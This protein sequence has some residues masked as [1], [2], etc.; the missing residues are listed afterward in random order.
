MTLKKRYLRNIKNN[1]SFYICVCILTTLVV[2]LYLDFAAAAVKIGGD[3]DVFY[4]RFKVENAQFTVEDEISEEDIEKLEKKYDILL[5]KQRYIDYKV[6]KDNTVIGDKKSDKNVVN[7]K[8]DGYEYELRIMS[9]PKKINLFVMA[10]GD[11]ITSKPGTEVDKGK[12]IINTGLAKGNNIAKGDMITLADN[13]FEYSGE[14]ER[15]D[16]L[17]PIKDTSDTFALK[18]EFGIGMISDEEFEELVEDA[19][20]SDKESEGDSDIKEYY[21]IRYNKD[22]ESEVRKAINKEY[23]MLSYLKAE[24]NTRTNIPKT[25]IEETSNMMNIVILILVIFIS[26]IISVVIGRKIK[27][28]R[29]QIGVLIALGYR[30]N[31]LSMHYAMY[32]IILGLLGTGM[33]VILS[34]LL[35]DKLLSNLFYKI[36]PIPT[37]YSISISNML[38]AILVPTGLYTFS[39]YRSARKVMKTDVI[40]MI[41]GRSHGGVASKLRMKKSRLS[42]KTKFKLRQ[43]FGKPGRSI[44]VVIGLAF[45]GMLYAFCLSCIDSMDAYVKHTVDQIGTFNYEY[46]L[47]TPE[48]GEPE[49][50]NAILGVSY[51]VKGREDILMLL[52]IDSPDMINFKDTDGNELDFEED[53]YYITSMA[54]LAFNTEVGDEITIV[55]PITLDEYTV[56]ITDIVKNDSQAAIYCSRRNA[57]ELLDIDIEEYNKLSRLDEMSEDDIMD[58]VYD[59]LD[60]D[61]DKIEEAAAKMETDPTSV[62]SETLDMMER[63]KDLTEDDIKDTIEG[64]TAEELGVSELKLPYNVIMSEEQVD[65]DSDK[66]VKT[67]SK[68][69]L[70]DQINEVKTS[71][72]DLVGV[73]NIFAIIICVVVVYMMVNVLITESTPSVSMLKVLGYRNR[74]INSMVLNVYHFLVPIAIVLSFLLGFFG[75][76]GVFNANVSVYK[77]YLATCIYPISIVKMTILV[78]VSYILSLL[79]LRGKAGKVD[80]VESLKD[81]R[82]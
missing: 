38:I 28:D 75:T 2:V 43:I 63:A 17:F 33:G 24:T 60:I 80:L 48:L 7:A 4:D 35:S 18:S 27:N 53:H 73:I 65:I 3:L 11:V 9:V 68:Q 40:T 15:T 14:F 71:M 1:L 50:G 62:D 76:K 46:F 42:V 55:D 5:E 10:D 54:S 21:V 19:L 36:E 64:L 26:I 78:L 30:K 67:I 72:E 13:K 74:E 61:M 49:K 47:K 23:S 31:E 81:N 52:G 44:I 6:D 22:N 77:T 34:L 45:G 82:E 56:K 57:V 16:Y 29:R 69:S 58:I 51:E 20:D 12:I 41:S 32:G 66:L 39:V 70:A 59:K 37:A 8:D 25:E 79:L